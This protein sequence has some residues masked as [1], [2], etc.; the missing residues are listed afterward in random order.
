MQALTNAYQEL[1]E[2]INEANQTVDNISKFQINIDTI[3]IS[4]YA[5][6]IC[7]SIVNLEFL[8]KID[9]DSGY[10]SQR[11]F[12][13]VCFKDKTWLEREEYDGSEC[14]SYKQ[15]PKF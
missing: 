10:G 3:Q 5:N 1:M 14:W 7:P 11:L 4:Q 9:Y 8:K 12:G 6:I 15:Y 2:A 13:F